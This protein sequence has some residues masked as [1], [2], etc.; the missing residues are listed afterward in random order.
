MNYK[1]KKLKKIIIFCIFFYQKNLSQDFK[2]Y[3]IDQK[4]KID[5]IESM[6]KDVKRLKFYSLLP[7]V[8]YSPLNNGFNVGVDLQ[9]YITYIQQNQRNKIELQRLKLNFNSEL[10]KTIQEFRNEYWQLKNE[11]IIYL[12]EIELIKLYK[13]I[14]DL[15]EAQ[16]KNNKINLEDLLTARSNYQVK[17]KAVEGKKIYLNQKIQ[18][19][20]IKTKSSLFDSELNVLIF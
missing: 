1:N 10:D 19:F 8:S 16:F 18:E 14:A 3:K 12:Q 9:R 5:S 11:F 2:N 17:L 7:S 13:E 6:Y 4:Q 15:K 20:S